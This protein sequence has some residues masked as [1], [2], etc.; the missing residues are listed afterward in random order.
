MSYR[1]PSSGIYPTDL[2]TADYQA[3]VDIWGPRKSTF[4][5]IYRLYNSRL[6]THLFTSN[7]QEIDI[8]TGTSSFVESASPQFI[9]EGIAYVVGPDP[10]QDLYRFY[11]TKTSRHFYSA[12]IDERNLLM[13]SEQYASFIYEGVAFKVF[14]A[15]QEFIEASKTP[16]F[17]F[18]NPALNTHLYTANDEERGIWIHSTDFIN[19]G[20]AWYA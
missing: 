17:R 2:S 3:L 10:D 12:N 6:D 16:V 11:D 9:N 5:E 13:S 14:S 19:E 18:Y 15:N 8:L 4:Q 1:T 7:L 20:I